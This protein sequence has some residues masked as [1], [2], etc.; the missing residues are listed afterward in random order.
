[1]ATEIDRSYLDNDNT[2]QL[3]LQQTIKRRKQCQSTLDIFIKKD[4]LI[5]TI[6]E[7]VSTIDIKVIKAAKPGLISQLGFENCKG[8]IVEVAVTIK[9]TKV[10]VILAQKTIVKYMVQVFY[11]KIVRIS[12]ANVKNCI[13][14]LI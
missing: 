13:Y 9:K 5:K 3:N 2:V 1:M 8:K 10:V 7:S 6:K 11:P 14:L 4:G 12:Q